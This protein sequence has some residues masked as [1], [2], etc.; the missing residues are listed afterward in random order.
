M[1]LSAV[2]RLNKKLEIDLTERTTRSQGAEAG[3]EVARQ[4]AGNDK[5]ALQ[6]NNAA[7]DRVVQQKIE[8]LGGILEREYN[9]SMQANQIVADAADT[10]FRR[11]IKEGGP[12]T[13]AIKATLPKVEDRA[14]ADIQ[15]QF[16]TW[17]PNAQHTLEEYIL[18][19]N[20]VAGSPDFTISGNLPKL[21]DGSV[22][23]NLPG[24]R[25]KLADEK[26][27]EL[28]ILNSK[29]KQME[30]DIKRPANEGGEGNSKYPLTDTVG[31]MMNQWRANGI[32]GEVV[33]DYLIR[34]KDQISISAWSRYAQELAG[35]KGKNPEAQQ[36]ISRVSK[37]FDDMVTQMEG[38]IAEASFHS[39]PSEQLKQMGNSLQDVVTSKMLEL[40]GEK[41]AILYLEFANKGM[42]DPFFGW[43]TIHQGGS[44][45]A[46]P[47]R[48]ERKEVVVG[49]E[50]T[51]KAMENA[52]NYS[53]AVIEKKLKGSGISI[54]SV[55]K[56]KDAQGGL[57]G[58]LKFKG[59]DGNSYRVGVEKGKAHMEV[60]R[61]GKTWEV[62]P[63]TGFLEFIK[64]TATGAVKGFLGGK[65]K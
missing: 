7:V 11:I 40:Q 14:L 13:E 61:D 32:D 49:G 43:D 30:S 51:T 2:A 9:N 12:H 21:P 8:D 35:N 15:K 31:D 28:G 54:I 3:R 17:N 4:Q 26:A 19:R 20:Q 23:K 53:R 60:M 62:V 25:G 38:Q 5:E 39:V 50:K 27:R 1:E 36:M 33:M 57:E 59:S 34:N 29:I 63:E 64:K 18:K 56:V 45:S 47:G 37:M 6:N 65:K 58:S 16:N 41:Q 48:M 42:M 46:D 52:L 44:S 22:V 10:A 55:E 24:M